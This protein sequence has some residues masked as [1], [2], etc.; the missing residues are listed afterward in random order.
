MDKLLYNKILISHGT[1]DM[2][3]VKAIIA[4]RVDHDELWDLFGEDQFLDG[5]LNAAI[6]LNGPTRFIIVQAVQEVDHRIGARGILGKGGRQKDTV[7]SRSSKALGV[8]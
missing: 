6:A 4:P 3:A 7:A 8:K 5:V 1:I 2:V